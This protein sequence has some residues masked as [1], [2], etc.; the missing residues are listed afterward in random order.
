MI[1]PPVEHDCYLEHI[2]YQPETDPEMRPWAVSIEGWS[3]GKMTVKIHHESLAGGTARFPNVHLPTPAKF[4]QF[5]AKM[6]DVYIT[7][8]SKPYIELRPIDLLALR[9]GYEEGERNAKRY[10]IL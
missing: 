6:L 8:M 10:R 1:A 5:V 3:R 2:I 4:A 7:T 9:A